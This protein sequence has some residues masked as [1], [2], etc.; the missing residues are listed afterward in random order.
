MKG[1]IVGLLFILGCLLL[2]FRCREE[3]PSS[4]YLNVPEGAAQYVGMK[5]C[6]VC[7]A[8][9]YE[10]FLRTG[11]GQSWGLATPQKSAAN[12]N[13]KQALVY[14]SFSNF[15]Y[16]PFWKNDSLYIQEFRLAQGDTVHSRTERVDYIVGSGQHTNSHLVNTNGYL[17]QAPI[18][19]YTQKGKWDM[20]PGFEHGHNTRFERKIEAE[21]I[22]CHNGYPTM[23]EGSL[24]K[25][26]QIP[27]GIDCERCHGPG[28]IHVAKKKNAEIVDTSKYIDYS[29]VNPKKLSTEAQNNLCQ[30]CHL[31]GITVLNEGKTFFDFKPSQLLKNSMNTFMPVYS[32]D[33]NHMIMAS[34][35]ERMKQS[36]CYINS[37][38]MSCITCHN[39]HISVKETPT[40][41]YN[42]SCKGCHA[43]AQDCKENLQARQ[44]QQDNCVHC[45][46]PKNSSID[47]PHVAVTDHRIQVKKTLTSEE[48]KAIGQF[49][50]MQCYSNNEVSETTRGQAFLEFFE[51]Y[52]EQ[53]IFLDSAGKYFRELKS[54]H[55]DKIRYHFLRK[56]YKPL[57]DLSG[58]LPPDKIKDA[59]TNYRMGEAL[60][61]LNQFDKAIPY[62][63]QACKL[64]PYA[65]DFQ[66]KLASTLMK[67]NRLDEA[68]KICL[69]IIQENPNY[70]LSYFNLGYVA[71]QK[72]ELLQAERY[73]LLSKKYNPDH[74]QTLINLSVLYYR[75][76]RK[77]LIRP[78]LE[79]AQRAEP[80][81]QQVNAMLMDL[82]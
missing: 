21:C 73:Y 51:R 40:S 70:G 13:P 68:R 72:Q 5:E 67:A 36:N 19:F 35:V 59:W 75:S 48:T 43:Q 65:L 26:A 52:E 53:S 57:A 41:V 77:A 24:N 25:Y 54:L 50:R 82:K 18:T 46:M 17:H 31:Q 29:I 12:F 20:A 10:T 69:F 79:T 28:S 4:A 76:N 16:K 2:F 32:A 56:E 62:L 3:K 15:Y 47:I 55:P 37:G 58:E 9:I 6:K 45:H 74:V 27:L 63:Q 42:Q 34:H 1:R 64:K 78:L 7:H 23:V 33:D 49:V 38:K 11:M 61:N 8:Q 66:M 22:T 60:Q 39:P 44:L 80:R 71:E 30:R 81:N 14:D